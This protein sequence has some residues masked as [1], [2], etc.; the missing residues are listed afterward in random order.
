MILPGPAPTDI[1]RPNAQLYGWKSQMKFDI[2][3]G[4][5]S[6]DAPLYVRAG[7]CVIESLEGC[8]EIAE[9][10]VLSPLTVKKHMQRLYRKLGVN[11]RRAA[12]GEARRLGLI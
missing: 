10:L 3:N 7:A 11:N 9:R 2:G 12:V 6:L 1:M 4:L 8:L 5:V